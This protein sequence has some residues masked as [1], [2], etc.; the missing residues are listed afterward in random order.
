[1]ASLNATLVITGPTVFQD[2][3]EHDLM[4]DFR[5][6][7]EGYVGYERFVEVLEA[8]P[9]AGGVDALLDDLR[10]LYAALVDAG[11]FT[12]DE[13]PILDAWIADMETLGVG[14]KA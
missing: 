11:F 10:V 4:R 13:L 3:N 6:E 14:P 1:M 8:T 2:R 9:I 12:C 5:E 7:I